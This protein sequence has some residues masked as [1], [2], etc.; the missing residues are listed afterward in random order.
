MEDYRFALPTESWAGLTFVRPE[1]EVTR[2][3]RKTVYRD[4]LQYI[5]IEPVSNSDYQFVK[6]PL[7]DLINAPEVKFTVDAGNRFRVSFDA[8][9]PI[10]Y[11]ELLDDN[12]PVYAATRDGKTYW[13]ESADRKVFCIH[14]QNIGRFSHVI[15]GS[16]TVTGS[17]DVLWMEDTTFTWPSVMGKE[18]RKNSLKFR[19]V[20]KLEANRFFFSIPAAD[21]ENAVLQIRVP[22]FFHQDLPLARFFPPA[23]SAYRENHPVMSVSR[24]DFQTL[25]PVN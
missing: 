16:F 23:Y 20:Q 15:D 3:G 8:K 14:L 17:D 25:Q 5:K 21:A 19:K 11:A 22:G 1:L 9:E 4:G 13:K 7:R 6:Q 18:L 12:M 10:A 2:N 24:Q